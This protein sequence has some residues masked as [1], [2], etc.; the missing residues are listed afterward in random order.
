MSQRFRS[1]LVAGYLL[2]CILLGGSGQG[3]WRNLVLQI[4]GIGLIA[5][6]AIRPTPAE[7]S[8]ERALGLYAIAAL[9]GLIVFVQLIPLPAEIWPSLPGRASLA[10]AEHLL[11][12][13]LPSMAISEAPYQS[14]LT[15][16]AVL[17]PLA[18]F[19]AVK[20]WRPTAGWLALAIAAGMACS[21]TL[22]AIQVA[23][24]HGS[25]AYLYEITNAG[26]VGLFANAN[27]MGTLL[28][29][30]IPFATALLVSSKSDRSG[31]RE[32]RMAVGIAALVL[33]LI[34]IALNGSRAA[35]ALALPV[36][37]ATVALVPAAKR[38]RRVALP[39]GLIALVAA[40]ATIAMKPV[41]DTEASMGETRSEIWTT[42][43][44]AIGDTFPVGSGLG[45]F[46]QVY[47]QH[48]DPAGVTSQ[49]VNHAHNDYLE[50]ALELGLPGLLLII[51]FLAWWALAS[52][53]VWTSPLS[54]PVGRAATIASAA[55]L[56]H[57]LVDY[58]LRTA[59]I[60]AIFGVSLAL[61][62]QR[63]RTEQ[64]RSQRETRPHKHVSLG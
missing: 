54:T 47:R 51:A 21:I 1:I 35:V 15:L 55:V 17:P 16:F 34:G 53:R 13:S 10:Q 56:A 26:A 52:F 38:W 7:D 33:V 43:A 5:W 8:S 25:W 31:S 22:G 64:T 49:Y 30:S 14:V 29:V 27:H 12:G 46:Q 9:G 40:V 45:T 20:L 24:G 19:V 2:L 4:L 32:G 39:V 28:L 60:S 63:N 58:P 18:A 3:L 36:M 41:G 59:A 23:G 57:S 48:E 50:L 37:V 11:G 62:T 61:M 44:A 42:T 6:A